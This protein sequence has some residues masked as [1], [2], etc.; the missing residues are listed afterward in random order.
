MAQLP[1]AFHPPAARYRAR[2]RAPICGVLIEGVD[3]GLIA[4]LSA[5]R[6]DGFHCSLA[7]VGFGAALRTHVR[8]RAQ[9]EKCHFGNPRKGP[10]GRT[11]GTVGDVLAP[12]IGPDR[13]DGLPDDIKG[14]GGIYLAY[15][16]WLGKMM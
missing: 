9:S 8:H 12:G 15:H 16:D 5:G 14:P 7:D 4:G 1:Y 11:P 13:I 6:S 2:D 10:I 3:G